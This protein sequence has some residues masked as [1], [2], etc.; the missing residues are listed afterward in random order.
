MCYTSSLINRIF[1]SCCDSGRKPVRSCMSVAE[2]GLELFC[3]EAEMEMEMEMKM[4]EELTLL[5]A[6]IVASLEEV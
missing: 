1:S 5:L 4:P 3:E 6:R 2:K